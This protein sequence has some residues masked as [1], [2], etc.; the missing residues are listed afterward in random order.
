MRAMWENLFDYS[1]KFS[2]VGE[3]ISWWCDISLITRMPDNDWIVLQ[4]ELMIHLID[5]AISSL[6]HRKFPA[7]YKFIAA[8]R[9]R[10]FQ[11]CA[12][13]KKCQRNFFRSLKRAKAREEELLWTNN[14]R[15]SMNFQHVHAPLSQWIINIIVCNFEDSAPECCR[16]LHTPRSSRIFLFY[17]ISQA[18]ADTDSTLELSFGKLLSL[19]REILFF[20]VQ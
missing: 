1:M 7:R 10:I 15:F 3:E 14:R 16:S 4:H 9:L 11:V 5:L 12:K 19:C 20:A 2:I 18:H 13:K 8:I 17:I 6:Y